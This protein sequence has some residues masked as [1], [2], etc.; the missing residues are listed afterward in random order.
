MQ[1]SSETAYDLLVN[2]FIGKAQII[3][4]L[5]L[6]ETRIPLDSAEHIILKQAIDNKDYYEIKS[7]VSKLNST[8]KIL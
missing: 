3:Q 2:G 4:T 5:N 6:G 1:N 8:R 7:I